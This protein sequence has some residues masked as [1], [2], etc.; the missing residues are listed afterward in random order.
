V[1]A[2][3]EPPDRA[4]REEAVRARG[5]NV[6][7]DAGAG[8]GKTTL[9]VRRL[10]EM[11]AP[12][13]DREPALPL[14]RIA[15]VTFTRKA[16]GELRLRV[17]EGLLRSLAGA[18][19]PGRRLRLARALAAA[20][21]AFIGTIHGFADRLLRRW[22][23]EAGLSPSYEVVEDTDALCRET[24][25]ALLHAAGSGGLADE[26]AGSASCSPERAEEAEAAIRAALEA[27]VPAESREGPWS[28]RNGLDSLF[29]AFI[30]NRD[31]PPPDR[32]AAPFQR[33][34]LGEQ[35]DRFLVL[36]AESGG[37]GA[38][39]VWMAETAEALRALAGET[40]P[41]RLYRE[42]GRIVRYAP[43]GNQAFQKK[44]DFPE[45]PGGWTAWKAWC[46]DGEGEAIRDALTRPLRRFMATRLAR[47]FP[48][49]VALYEIV[50]ARH[51]V[52]DQL[53]LLLKLRDLLRG[54][55][56][57]RA[58]LQAQ[59]DHVFV[60]EFQDTDPLQ[61]EVVLYLCEDEARATDWRQVRLAPGKL[62]IVGDPK[63]S[64]YRFRRADIAVYEEVRR[65]VTAG[66][67]L[68]V[69]L[70]ANFRSEPALV[71]HLNDRYDEI[72]GTG[73]PEFDRDAGT[74]ANRRLD[75]FREKGREACVVVL[76][77]ASGERK[78]AADRALEAKA[79]ATWIR[80][81][82]RD[83]TEA[84]ADPATGDRRPIR[85]GDVAVLAHSTWNVGLLVGELDRL[86]VPWSARGGTLFLDDPL[87]RQFLLGLR[88]V[89]NREDGVAQA[90]L[91]RA[92]FFALDLA[93][94]T[95]A[96]APGDQAARGGAQRARAA[97]AFVAELRR[98]RLSRSPG[99]TARDLLERTGFARAA[100]FGPN[101]AQRLDRLR[102]LC[103]EVERLAAADGLDYDGVT[104][105][106]RQW[107]LQ[108]VGLDPPRP[109]GG[110]AV[111]ILTIHQAK[112]LEFPVVVWWDARAEMTPR[113][114]TFPW[115][116]DRTGSAWALSLDGLEWQE[117]EESG[118]LD[119][120]R[121]YRAAE[122]LRLVYVAGTRARDLLV[123]P[124]A[125]DGRNVTAALAGTP[126][127]EAASVLEAWTADRVPRWARGVAPPPE[128]EPEAAGPALLE[129]QARY[130]EAAAE[131][132]RARLVPRGIAA[133][134][135]RAVEVEPEGEAGA[136]A[137]P[138]EGRH[139]RVFG[140]TVHAAIGL[141]L[142]EPGLEPGVAVARAART[143]G[144]AADLEAAAADVRRALGALDGAGLRR[145]PGPDLRLEYPVASVRAELLLSG[146]ID[147]VS[148][149]D[150]EVSVVDFKTDAPPRGDVRASYP[151]YA[152]Q[153]R[154][155]GRALVDLGLAAE[156]HV[157]CGLLFTADGTLRWV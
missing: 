149:R 1:S 130:A 115:F 104:A 156:G 40:D 70:T 9:L 146:Y 4:H 139:G 110:D 11:V 78:A 137:K 63:Q 56:R 22:P 143:T 126:P 105:R 21:T 113:E 46:G 59:F 27:E 15:A 134:A 128:R 17:R 32:K 144:L 8:T 20:D 136:P 39:S 72:L 79:L 35:V 64:I 33:A 14:E 89:A 154:G 100:A 119:R 148:S 129:A 125:D 124:L 12:E 92:P 90:A 67:C 57:A 31:V 81:A 18:L 120:E 111:Q 60:D 141:S 48:A 16:A 34:R 97:E 52:V 23:V 151:A 150:G 152:E 25:D 47:T 73:R 45:D 93:D 99:D 77:L 6:L 65:I 28:T 24:F 131:A 43:R 116:V 94:L 19:S 85:Y 82:V 157:R 140:E 13:D 68:H 51:R 86:G 98:R 71:A 106:T 62:T 29:E 138:R 109:V 145:M 112:G 101:G 61:A 96:R 114:R 37:T 58:E 102:E 127:S 76:P 142:R 42:I 84:I 88:A 122:R 118:I 121:A 26:L 49:V 44:R 95:R 132:G 91:F 2:A 155:Y 133:E 53:D 147:L 108:P 10:L 54:N 135:H 123:L 83:G 5:V 117:P 36:A 7:V 107:A 74:V 55:L 87:H 80:A 69:P 75:A 30:L 41:V 3:R 103:F 50:K 66:R 153:V 38:G